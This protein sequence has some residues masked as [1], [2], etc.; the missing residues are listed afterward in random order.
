MFGS[1]LNEKPDASRLGGG[2][3]VLQLAELYLAELTT[4]RKVAFNS[5]RAAGPQGAFQNS[6]YFM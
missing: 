3:V 5:K 6:Q 1:I 2:I 4:H